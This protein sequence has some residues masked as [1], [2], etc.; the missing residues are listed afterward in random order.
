MIDIC[1]TIT[2]FSEAL[3]LPEGHKFSRKQKLLASFFAHF[4]TDED[5]FWC[6]VSTNYF[7]HTD[8]T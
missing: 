7:E 8:T 1:I 2:R 6:G 5:E 3:T 4:S